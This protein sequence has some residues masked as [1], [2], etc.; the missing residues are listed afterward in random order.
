MSGTQ[1]ALYAYD[2]NYTANA[3]SPAIFNLLLD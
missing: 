2:F 1:G 3:M